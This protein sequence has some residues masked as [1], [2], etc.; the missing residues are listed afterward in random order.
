MHCRRDFIC[1]GVFDLSLIHIY[2]IKV[3]NAKALAGCFVE[4]DIVQLGVVVSDA[5]RQF[6]RRQQVHHDMIICFAG[7]DKLDLAL[8]LCGTAHAILGHGALEIGEALGRVMKVRNRLIQGMSRI[9]S[10]LMLEVT[11]CYSCLLYT[12][13]CV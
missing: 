2:G 8:Y 4:Q 3:D 6:T 9:L 12:S 1:C 10:Q 7:A 13:R 11:E 5:Q